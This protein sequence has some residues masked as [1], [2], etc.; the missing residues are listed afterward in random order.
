MMYKLITIVMSSTPYI[1]FS[2][3]SVFTLETVI[4]AITDCLKVAGK[5]GGRVIGGFVRDVIVP[6]Y[7]GRCGCKFNDVDVWFQT[8]DVA[9]SFVKEM[10]KSFVLKTNN[11]KYDFMHE[12]YHLYKHNTCIAWFDVV[13]S[14][15]IPVDDFNVNMLTYKYMPDYVLPE[16]FSDESISTL[17]RAIGDRKTTILPGY[18]NYLKGDEDIASRKL[19]RLKRVFLDRGWSVTCMTQVPSCPNLSW[20]REPA[21]NKIQPFSGDIISPVSAG[22]SSTGAVPHPVS[23]IASNTAQPCSGA[24]AHPVSTIASNIAQ[25]VS[26]IASNTAQPS[27]GAVAR[28]ASTVAPN[29]SYTG[30][31]FLCNAVISP[32]STVASNSSSL[33]VLSSRKAEIS[34]ASTVTSNSS[35]V[36]ALSSRNGTISQSDAGMSASSC[37]AVTSPAEISITFSNDVSLQPQILSN[38]QNKSVSICEIKDVTP[39]NVNVP[40]FSKESAEIINTAIEALKLALDKIIIHK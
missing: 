20:F 9:D 11:P 35:C 40:E 22:A 32:V 39:P 4:E 25:P 10:G 30:E 8:R 16:S 38:Q 31:P 17:I 23:T 14:K 33:E 2:T 29:L 5:Y 24:V 3:M 7:Y 37:T 6:R 19:E 28:P 18:L 12:K 27:S 36:G 26:T 1:D 13:V 21:S 15:I 34:P